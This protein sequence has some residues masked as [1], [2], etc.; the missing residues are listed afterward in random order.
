MLRSP[1][2]LHGILKHIDQ[3]IKK[4][5]KHRD[6]VAR[7]KVR[8]L[9]TKITF[10]YLKSKKGLKSVIIFL[11]AQKVR[12]GAQKSGE[13]VALHIPAPPPP[14][15]LKRMYFLMQLKR[16]NVA[17]HELSRFYTSC[18]RSV[19]TCTSPAFF[20]ALPLYLKKDLENVEKRA[21]SIICPGLAYREALK[22]SN[23]M[24]IDYIASLCNKTFLS[25]ANDP[26]N[27]LHKILQSSGPSCYNLRCKRRFS[28]P[29]CRTE[30]FKK[31][32][33]VRS[34]INNEF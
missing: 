30:R 25:T 14:R 26:A 27:R 34:C 10:S 22:L 6:H 12:A 11:L 15:Y 31:S 18:I 33:L 19:L 16:A 13:A 23:I 1:T 17:G 32:F 24:S 20:Y 28:I 4:A 2:T 8:G 29:K 21:L 5:L 9:T 7:C 3:T